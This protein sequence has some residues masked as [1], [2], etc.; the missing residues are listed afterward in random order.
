MQKTG[1]RLRQC[2]DDK[3]PSLACWPSLTWRRGARDAGLET[4]VAADH[5]LGTI[6]RLAD[7]ALARLT[8]EFG[9]MYDQ[10]GRS[11]RLRSEQAFYLFRLELAAPD[12]CYYEG[13]NNAFELMCATCDLKAIEAFTVL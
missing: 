12:F 2:A 8:L 3:S 4:R 10:V 1:G 7:R 5:P 11:L 13:I 6:N 9:H